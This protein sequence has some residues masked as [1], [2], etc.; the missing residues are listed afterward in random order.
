[1]THDRKMLNE[2]IFKIVFIKFLKTCSVLFPGTFFTKYLFNSLNLK[3]THLDKFQVNPIKFS[4]NFSSQT[5]HRHIAPSLRES[6]R[7]RTNKRVSR[8]AAGRR[9]PR[10]ARAKRAKRWA[11]SGERSGHMDTLRT[12]KAALSSVVG[13]DHY[14]K[15]I[16]C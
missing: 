14:W 7:S 8:P 3:N 6:L 5:S 1:M 9:V 10:L 11:V 15:D 13:S 2:L 12:K 16:R 4:H